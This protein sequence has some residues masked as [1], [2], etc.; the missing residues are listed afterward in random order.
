MKKSVLFALAA[1]LLLSALIS[2]SAAAQDQSVLKAGDYTAKVKAIV[3]GG[4][5]KLIQDTLL[6]MKEIGSASVDMQK[7]TLKF[8]VKKDNTVKVADL[9]K[10]L[11]AAAAQMGMGADYELSELKPLK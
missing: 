1:F 11:K 6:K 5:G 7:S 10:A 2:A 8:S 4:C 9:Q 3:C